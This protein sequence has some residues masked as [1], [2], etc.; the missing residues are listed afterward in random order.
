MRRQ[1]I[2]IWN[3][4]AWGFRMLHRVGDWGDQRF[5]TCRKCGKSVYFGAPCI[6]FNSLG[7][8]YHP[9]DPRD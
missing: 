5:N 1:F 2:P 4:I 9:A 6:S 8:G 3:L 7:D